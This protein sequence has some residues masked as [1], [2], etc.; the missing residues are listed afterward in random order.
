MDYE[1]LMKLLIRILFTLAGLGCGLFVLNSQFN[2]KNNKKAINQK[3]AKTKKRKNL[4]QEEI[5]SDF[6]EGLDE[7][8][9]ENKQND[10]IEDDEQE[11][12]SNHRFDGLTTEKEN[13]VGGYTEE[14][15]NLLT[16]L[17]SIAEDQ[18]RKEGYIHRSITCNNCNASPIRGYRYK[19]ANCVDFDLCESCEALDL[20]FKTHVSLKIKI[21]IPPLANPRAA[22]LSSFYPVDQVELEAFYEQF[23]SLSTVPTEEGGITKEIFEQCLGPLGL[24]KNLIAERIFFFFDQNHDMIISFPELVCGMSILCKGSL[25]ERIKYAFSGYDLDGDGCISRQELHKMFKAYFHLSMELVRDVV[26][27]MEEGMMES[28]DDQNSKPV[29][30]SFTAP[31]PSNNRNSPSDDENEEDTNEKNA[32]KKL[33]KKQEIPTG[34]LMFASDINQAPSS[35]HRPSLSNLNNN[36]NSLMAMGSRTFRLPSAGSQQSPH[37]NTQFSMLGSPNSVS[38][39][40][41]SYSMMSPIQESSSPSSTHFPVRSNSPISF[42]DITTSSLRIGNR[43]MSA[44]ATSPQNNLPSIPYQRERLGSILQD[45]TSN[46]EHWPVMEAM[47]QDAIEEMVERTFLSAGAE[48]KDKLSF[49]D[50]KRV[51][52]KDNNM[53]AWFEALG[54]VF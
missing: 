6:E 10:E 28:F 22:L 24:E 7:E 31:I 30:A 23:K 32:K 52:E 15:Q 1:T 19:C 36:N 46:E 44:S 11:E 33:S 2:Q 16:L 35:S 12:D 3:N 41:A 48:L 4:V 17:Y 26:K 29:S 45:P 8:D 18:A 27:T 13:K 53:L 20:H 25:D 9:D 5:E 40:L 37:L 38:Q 51:V 34:S 42:E 54:S 49:E 43:P 39:Q 47:S 50:F 14:S 21:P